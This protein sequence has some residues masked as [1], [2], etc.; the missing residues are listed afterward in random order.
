[1][2]VSFSWQARC[3]LKFCIRVAC[4]LRWIFKVQSCLIFY[5]PRLEIT[6]AWLLKTFS[7]A[8]SV[9]NNKQLDST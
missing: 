8:F 2:C 4:G 3:D 5:H 6:L 1:M 7:V 9:V